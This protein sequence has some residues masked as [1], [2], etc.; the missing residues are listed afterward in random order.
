MCE[1]SLTFSGMEHSTW[2]A[3]TTGDSV[4]NVAITIGLP[5]RTL[6]TQI[7]K[8]R[9]S[10]EN[11]IKI[12]EHY[13]IH[14]VGALV[15]TGYLD[16]KWASEVDP[17]TAATQLTDEQLAEEILRRLREVRGDHAVFHTPVADLDAHRSNNTNE[18][19]EPAPYAANRREL[20]PEEGD[21]D[22]G[23]GA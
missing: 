19:V 20:E 16:K 8:G 2:L 13:D 18:D 14:P 23:P 5:P 12:A 7:E 3:A 17:V 22:Y 1:L 6:A 21:D 4:R 9:I 15:D 10:P 11:V